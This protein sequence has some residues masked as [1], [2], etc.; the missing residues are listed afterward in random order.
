MTDLQE[1]ARIGRVAQ[2][3]WDS[4]FDKY[5]AKQFAII[6]TEFKNA[7]SPEALVEISHRLKAIQYIEQSIKTDIETGYLAQQQLNLEKQ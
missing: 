6:Y 3:V 4:Y 1:E 7:E 5:I 2:N